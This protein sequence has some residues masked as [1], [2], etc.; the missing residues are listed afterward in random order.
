MSFQAERERLGKKKKALKMK[1]LR[2]R[3]KLWL[4]FIN[5]LKWVLVSFEK[6]E[7]GPGEASQ[8]RVRCASYRLIRRETE[9]LKEQL[10]RER[11]RD[12]LELERATLTRKAMENWMEMILENEKHRSN[13]GKPR[14]KLKKKASPESARLP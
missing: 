13:Q 12:R 9:E 4:N 7:D 5:G 1:L 3:K 8:G 2:G 6:R 14:L 10:R 11:E